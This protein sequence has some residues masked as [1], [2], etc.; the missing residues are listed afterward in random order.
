MNWQ[1]FERSLFGKASTPEAGAA[2][3]APTPAALSPFRQSLNWIKQA[4]GLQ[5]GSPPQQLDTSV[6]VA[7]MDALQDG[8]PFAR[9]EVFTTTV[10]VGGQTLMPRDVSVLRRVI[11][12]DMAYIDL[13]GTGVPITVIL[14]SGPW[15]NLRSGTGANVD[16]GVSKL[17]IG[18]TVEVETLDILQSRAL[19]IPPGTSLSL[20][21][22]IPV[23]N[24]VLVNVATATV[25]AGFRP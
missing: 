22:V 8:W 20:N 2:A 4:L 11:A 16:V 17:T 12:I 7:A 15:S 18:A 24:N 21:G 25:P 1:E 14:R 19:Y 23:G 9:F 13:L 6:I 5:S 10:T 3:T